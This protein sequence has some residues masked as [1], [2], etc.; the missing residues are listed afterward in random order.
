MLEVEQLFTWLVEGAPGAD[1][2]AAVVDRIGQSLCAAGIPIDRASALIRTL[3]PHIMGRRF[4]WSPGQPVAIAEASYAILHSP[5]FL[6][7]PV[8]IVG[9]TKQTYRARLAREGSASE[10][11]LIVSLRKEGFTDYVAIPLQ[12]INGE[13]HT[14]TFATK[15][16]SGFSDEH[17]AALHRIVHPLARIAEIMALRRTAANLL[18]TY[19]GRNAGER[20][21]GGQI[22]RGD[23]DA[24]HA[25]IWFS[26]IRGFTALSDSISP[27]ALIRMLNEVF[28][29]QV[30]AI[31]RRGGEVLK[32]IGDGLLAIFPTAEAKSPAAICDEALEAAKDAFVALDALNQRRREKGEMPVRFGLSLHIGDV[33]YGNIGGAGRL[34]FTCIGPAVNLAAR[35][36]GLTSQLKRDIVTSAAFAALA[37][38]PMEPIGS[39]TLKGVSQ[40]EAVYAPLGKTSAG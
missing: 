13:V 37:T 39:F 30:T 2:P 14:M 8:A 40:A 4:T 27:E 23:T 20:I 5:E 12:F 38:Q 36:E 10:P 28:E 17:I 35:L 29:C 19:V 15:H 26:D 18:S 16:P 7:S 24:V 9:E 32:F 22:L 3:H 33:A 25:V 6:A 11:P 31:Q 34:D 1:G 21:L